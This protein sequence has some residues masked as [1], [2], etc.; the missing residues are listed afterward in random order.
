[1]PQEDDAEGGGM[2]AE[3]M[4]GRNRFSDPLLLATPEIR[5][6]NAISV[7]DRPSIE[8]SELDEV[9]LAGREVIA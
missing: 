9:E 7:G 5:V 6:G 3:G 2:R 1:M 4:N 8:P